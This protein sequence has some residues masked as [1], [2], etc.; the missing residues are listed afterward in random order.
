MADQRVLRGRVVSGTRKAAFFTQLDWVI[1]QCSQKLGF[2]P[3]P[4]TLNVEV[5]PESHP[6]IETLAKENTIE[7]VSPDPGFCNAQVIPATIE[8]ISAAVILPQKNVRVHGRQIIEVI[9]PVNLR[10]KL[11]ID[12]GNTIVLETRKE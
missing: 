12:D 1:E 4:G 10:N 5:R 8:G 11:N 7:L 6:Q 9:A 3:F 2:R